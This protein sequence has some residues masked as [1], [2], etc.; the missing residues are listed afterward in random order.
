MNFYCRDGFG[1]PKTTGVTQMYPGVKSLLI[2]YR[3]KLGHDRVGKPL[4]EV[5]GGSLFWTRSGSRPS[6]GVANQRAMLSLV[7]ELEEAEREQPARCR[8]IDDAEREPDQGTDQSEADRS[9]NSNSADSVA[10]DKSGD[11]QLPTTS[12]ESLPDAATAGTSNA[13]P[14]STREEQISDVGSEPTSRDSDP[15][16][17]GGTGYGRRNNHR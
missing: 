8:T 10:A 9:D 2:G 5:R 4:A 17:N 15:P 13:N 3:C 16:I 6:H 14:A 12:T 7:D 11:F 1:P